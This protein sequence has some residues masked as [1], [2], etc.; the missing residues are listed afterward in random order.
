MSYYNL[1]NMC[2][3]DNLKL[4]KTWQASCE[5]GVLPMGGPDPRFGNKAFKEHKRI[6][7]NN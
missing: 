3:L 6:K 7:K 5:F 4:D 2:K 1:I